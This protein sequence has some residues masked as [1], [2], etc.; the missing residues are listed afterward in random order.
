MT[1]HKVCFYRGGRG[2]TGGSTLMDLLVQR[3]RAS[4]RRVR[5][6]DG[7]QNPTL[8]ERY[9]P[10]APDGCFVPVSGDP[11]DV[12]MA[13]TD[14]LGA[15]IAENIS[16]GIDLGG[17]D[18]VMQEHGHDLALERF[19]RKRG[20][21]PLAAYTTGPDW[22]DFLHVVKLHRAGFFAPDPSLLLLNEA[23]VRAGQSPAI[24]FKAIHDSPEMK[25]LVAAGMKVMLFPR[26]PCMEAVRE[27]GLTYAD[28][29]AGKPGQNGKPLDPAR[30]FMV[31]EW[32]ER[33]EA[34]FEK[35]GVAELLP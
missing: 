6:L 15:M 23:L 10:A 7:A 35:L 17:G 29:A 12:K 25:E 28:A 13:V 27:A 16:L 19:C 24:A 26:L 30:A 9:P 33:I 34:G 11:A 32:L 22:D 8:A 21:T 4:G 20:W 3:A 2:R 5:V 14:A 1:E 31:E 18:R